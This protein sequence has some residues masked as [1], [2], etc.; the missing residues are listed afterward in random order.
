MADKEGDLAS[1]KGCREKTGSLGDVI[2]VVVKVG[3]LRVF[4]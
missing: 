4:P 1:G 3:K 2:E